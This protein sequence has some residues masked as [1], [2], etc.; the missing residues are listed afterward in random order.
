MSEL[1]TLISKIDP[2][3]K[4]PTKE[5]LWDFIKIALTEIGQINDL[6]KKFYEG[7]DGAPAL[8]SDIES[9]IK[10]IAESYDELYPS[11]ITDDSVVSELKTQIE[12]IREFHSKLLTEDDSIEKDIIDFQEKITS[13]YIKL[14]GSNGTD[15]MAKEIETFYTKLT[16]TDGIEEETNR[17][18][19]EI[20][21]KHA[22]LFDAEE[23]E[24]SVIHDLDSNIKKIELYKKKVD[25]EV[26]PEIEKAREYLKEIKIDIDTKLE[27]VSALLS[28]ATV[29]S[30]AEGYM[31]S[32]S[33]YSKQKYKV[34]TPDMSSKEK[35][36]I[37]LFNK[38]GRHITTLLNYSMF[39]LPLIAVLLVFVEE[40]TLEKIVENLNQNGIFPSSLE[41]IYIKTIISLP[42]IWI[43][44]YGQRNIS[45]RKRLFEEYNHKL[46]VVQ[47]YLLFNT[48]DKAYQLTQS[49]KDKLA[50]ILLDAIAY[51]P[52]KHL[53]KGETII[54]RVIERFQ[55][56]GV[57]KKIKAEIVSTLDISPTK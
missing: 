34:S 47:M 33:E 14:L 42:L 10:N 9:R 56:E 50:M 8:L 36:S 18:Y 13:F 20:L 11:G 17:I 5:Q 57:A 6:Y 37:F 24:T 46:R 27:D 44:L 15:G 22:E 52:A 31:E 29:K 53:G 40:N 12:E 32:K 38:F 19:D 16:E 55:V 7:T 1:D 48:S 30:L 54:D 49:N 45:Q 3:K 2:D 25:T 41:L 28:D 23:G 26:T 21:E 4:S 43:A 35:F 51:N 39:I